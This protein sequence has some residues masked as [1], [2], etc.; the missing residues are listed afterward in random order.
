[1]TVGRKPVHSRES[2]VA[3]ALQLADESG[4]GAVTVRALGAEIH[5]S[6]TAIYRHFPTKEALISAIQD[7]LLTRVYAAWKSD[8]DPME[9]FVS[10]GRAL[11]TVAQRHP[12]LGQALLIATPPDVGANPLS[13]LIVALLEQMG[14]TGE[15]LVVGYRQLETLAIGSA[16]FDFSGAPTHLSDRRIRM[17]TLGHPDFTRH[18]NNAKA[19]ARINDQA[20]DAT[21]R[22]ILQD[23][24]GQEP[25]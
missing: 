19:V 10:L 1:M 17:H 22:L 14:V 20:F 24:S 3:A 9:S 7:H 15:R 25:N 16:I 18:L 12:S 6:A 11:R 5:A 21:L 23:L 8:P 4:I 2:F 13:T